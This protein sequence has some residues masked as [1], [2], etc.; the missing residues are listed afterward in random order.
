MSGEKEELA[1]EESAEAF[2]RAEEQEVNQQPN[3]DDGA[4]AGEGGGFLQAVGDRIGEVEEAV[5][6]AL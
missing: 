2:R 6:G 3:S 5:G 1:S 4:E